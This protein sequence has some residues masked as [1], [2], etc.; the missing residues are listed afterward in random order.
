MNMFEFA[1]KNKLRFATKVG[2]VTVED[3]WDLPLTSTKGVSLDDTAKSINKELKS[4]EEESFVVKTIKT[5][6]VL[7]LKLDIVK[8]IIRVRLD[9]N[10]AAQNAM[11]AK[12]KKQKIMELIEAKK[13]EAMAGKS[14]DELEA[15]LNEL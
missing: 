8:H 6:E 4:S 9:E 2:E 3:L 12:A 14:L 7:G 10:E 1:T 5:N 13:N 11:V 15:M